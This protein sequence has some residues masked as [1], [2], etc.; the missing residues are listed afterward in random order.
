[1][2]HGGAREWPSGLAP[3]AARL[4]FPA[5]VLAMNTLSIPPDHRHSSALKTTHQAEALAPSSTAPPSGAGTSPALPELLRGMFPQECG[6]AS[7]HLSSEVPERTS[8]RE[9][10]RHAVE[11]RRREFRAGRHAARLALRSIGHEAVSIP[12]GP[13]REPVWPHG[14]TGSIAHSGDLAIAVVASSPAITSV[15]VDVEVAGAVGRDLWTACFTDGE[16]DWLESRESQ[17]AHVDASLLFSAKEAVFKALFP[18]TR[19]W[20]D[21]PEVAVSLD[22]DHLH[23]HAALPIGL[24]ALLPGMRDIQGEFRTCASHVFTAVTIRSTGSF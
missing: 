11:G 6:V 24:S 22:W 3:S 20:I 21:F 14:V 13:D 17:M 8:E 23:F 9:F 15:G 18:L 7:V 2:R 16:R 19:R 5:G 1:M 10:I 12:V 4:P